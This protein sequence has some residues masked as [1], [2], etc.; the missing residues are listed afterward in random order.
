MGKLL[1]QLIN[2]PDAG[3][4]ISIKCMEIALVKKQKIPLC[5][6]SAVMAG[7]HFRNNRFFFFGLGDL[8]HVDPCLP[9]GLS[10]LNYQ[11]FQ[12]TCSMLCHC[13]LLLKR[14]IAS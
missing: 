3:E 14:N 5:V 13:V 2:V 12:V 11:L 8:W 10:G 6:Q 4:I 1:I 9:E 7:F